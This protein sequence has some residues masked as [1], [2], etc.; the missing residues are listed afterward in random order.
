MIQ[1]QNFQNSMGWEFYKSFPN[2]LKFTRTFQHLADWTATS[3]LIMKSC[4]FEIGDKS[5]CLF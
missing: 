4:D 1:S 2:K 3:E 5:V